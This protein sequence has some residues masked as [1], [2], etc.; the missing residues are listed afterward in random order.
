MSPA[1][2]KLIQKSSS[3]VV[4]I[5]EQAAAERGFGAQ[6][7]PELAAAWATAYA[8]LS[9]FMISEACGRPAAAE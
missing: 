5:S 3:K 7:T 2:V 1:R 9:D 6:W 4:P 8:T